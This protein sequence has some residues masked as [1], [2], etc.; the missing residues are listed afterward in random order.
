MSSIQNGRPMSQRPKPTIRNEFGTKQQYSSVSDPDHQE[1]TQRIAKIVASQ[2]TEIDRLPDLICTFLTGVVRQGRPTFPTIQHRQYFLH[3]IGSLLTNLNGTVL[4]YDRSVPSA[5]TDLLQNVLTELSLHEQSLGAGVHKRFTESRRGQDF[6]LVLEE[7]IQRSVIAGV[8]Y[9][10]AAISRSP[11]QQ[12]SLQ[13]M[14]DL[15]RAIWTEIYRQYAAVIATRYNGRQVNSSPVGSAVILLQGNLEDL[16]V[17]PTFAKNTNVIV[18]V[19]GTGGVANVLAHGVNLKQSGE[20][21]SDLIDLLERYIVEEFPDLAD[22]PTRARSIARQH[23]EVISDRRFMDIAVVVDGTDPEKLSRLDQF[24]VEAVIKG[25]FLAPEDLVFDANLRIAMKCDKTD[26]ALHM[27]FEDPLWNDFTVG[28]EPFKMAIALKRSEFVDI[29]LQNSFPVRQFLTPK[30]YAQ[31]YQYALEG[32]GSEFWAHVWRQ[33]LGFADNDVVDEHFII[34]HLNPYIHQITGVEDYLDFAEITAHA[35]KGAPLTTDTDGERKARNALLVFAVMTYDEPMVMVMLK[36]SQDPI[37]NTLFAE[38]LFRGLARSCHEVAAK[39]ALVGVAN[40]LGKVAHDLYDMAY[41]DNRNRSRAML[42]RDL[43]DYKNMNPLRLAVE[44]RDKTFIAH[45]NVQNFLSHWYYGFISIEGSMNTVKL[46]LSAF[47]IFPMFIWLSFPAL[48]KSL[49]KTGYWRRR[50]STMAAARLSMTSYDRGDMARNLFTRPET[51]EG[52]EAYVANLGNNLHGKSRFGSRSSSVQLSRP[53]RTTVPLRKRI[54]AIWNSPCVKFFS[55]AWIYYAFFMLMSVDVMLPP[56]RYIG[57]DIAVWIW[58]LMRWIAIITKELYGWQNKFAWRPWMVTFE[59]ITEGVLCIL[60]FLYRIAPFRYDHPLAGRVILSFAVLYYAYRIWDIFYSMDPIIGPSI[61][62]IYRSFTIDVFQWAV[63]AYPAFFAVGL[64]WQATVLPDSPMTGD[65]WRKAAYRAFGT[66]FSYGD[67][68]V[69]E[70]TPSCDAS[71]INW[72]NVTQ[73]LKMKGAY[74]EERCW[75]GDYSDPSCNTVTFW[76]YAFYL[77][78]YVFLQLGTLLVLGCAIFTRFID[79][80]VDNAVIWKFRFA[81]LILEYGV[82]SSLPPPLNVFGYMANSIR[83]F[84]GKRGQSKVGVVKN[85]IEME[86]ANMPEASAASVSTYWSTVAIRYFL[87][88]DSEKTM[89]E[90]IA[91]ADAISDDIEKELNEFIQVL[92]LRKAE[93]FKSSDLTTSI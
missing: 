91:A 85:M 79:E 64:V 56:C 82:R 42:I 90:K 5:A 63:I 36:H 81:N 14:M 58:I 59:L 24:I 40:R 23:V 28:W 44:A 43:P 41:H 25:S 6:M 88:K 66:L 45:P 75:I 89:E 4:I 68:N 54:Y 93:M 2:C 61:R 30:R 60:I 49:E 16:A 7:C 19:G 72:S 13:F 32:H 38:C 3:G 34:K 86:Q 11:S 51:R 10:K 74:P 70:Y 55:S 80:W 21:E 18:V 1:Q 27:I 87:K 31:L 83:I 92:E 39:A 57:V 84:M 8:S 9:T 71:K 17:L 62:L 12:E 78:Y 35:L 29:F 50:R 52:K 33:G 65:E 69:L 47:L 53:E 20:D 48:E 46:L 22:D 76:S 77:H 15:E 67:P 73:P 37:P 26:L